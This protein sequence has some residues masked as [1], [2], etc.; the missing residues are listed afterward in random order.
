MW[1]VTSVKA[2]ALSCRN[3]TRP[4][5][6][7]HARS[8]LKSSLKSSPTMP[9]CAGGSASGPPGN[10][11]TAPSIIRTSCPCAMITAGGPSLSSAIALIHVHGPPPVASCA[12]AKVRV[13]SGAAGLAWGDGSRRKRGMHLALLPDRRLDSVTALAICR[14][15][16]EHI[17]Q[18]H[19][20]LRRAVWV[21]LARRPSA[22]H[23][24][25]PA[26]RVA[27]RWLCPSRR[28]MLSC[29]VCMSPRLAATRASSSHT[30]R[31]SGCTARSCVS[32]RC[33]SAALCSPPCCS[34]S[35]ARAY[36]AFRWCG[37]RATA[38]WRYA[39]RCLQP[40]LQAL[41]ES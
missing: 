34:S 20:V 23:A 28:A 18:H 40:P 33:T 29:S 19:H 21:G 7:A 37:S 17:L 24:V 4:P 15:A 26:L 3:S 32:K 11:S 41:E 25:A 10:L 31:L 30:A 22:R 27:R 1:A 8:I 5:A 13:R 39:L 36:T 6:P 2:P 38:R 9:S 14:I 16:P 35:C 12:T